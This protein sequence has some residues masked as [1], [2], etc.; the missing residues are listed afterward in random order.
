MAQAGA[1]LTLSTEFITGPVNGFIVARVARGGDRIEWQ[2]LVIE[3]LGTPGYSPGVEFFS[4]R[5]R[6]WAK[7]MVKV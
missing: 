4:Y 5:L 7:A 3:V 1:R 6:E 2:D